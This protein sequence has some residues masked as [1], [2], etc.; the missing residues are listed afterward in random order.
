MPFADTVI[1]KSRPQS[2][3]R[4]TQFMKVSQGTHTIRILQPQAKTIPQ[5]F[6]KGKGSI[7]CLEDECPIC[8]NNR[9]LWSK[10]DKEARKQTGYNAKS[11][12]FFVNVLDKTPAKACASCGTEH[13]DLRNTICTC[14][15]VLPEA[16][17]LNRVKVLSR[18]VTLRDDLDSIDRAIQDSNGEP[19][20]LM[21]YDI[22]LM[23]TGTGTDTKVTAVPRTEAN[24]PV[25]LTEELYDLEKVV[26]RLSPEEM[27][28]VQR[29]TS[30]KDI[31]AARRAKEDAE[32]SATEVTH[33]ASQQ[34]IDKVNDAVDA[35]F[36]KE[37]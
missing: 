36:N 23:V 8:A 33:L 7:L 34:E 15:E 30:L 25:E 17:P 3:I 35:L 2:E 13:K 9:S 28:D 32:I 1:N 4:K 29:G 5:H 14:G 11:Y 6:F 27:L 21:N 12:R 10:Y 26:I 19:I 16:K 18:G 24:E 37:E 20:G 22:M 31:F